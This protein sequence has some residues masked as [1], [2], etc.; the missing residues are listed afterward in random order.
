[1]CNFL[2]LYST[3]VHRL[4]ATVTYPGSPALYSL[5]LLPSPVLHMLRIEITSSWI[6]ASLEPWFRSTLPG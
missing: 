2:H 1:M 5:E 3:D 4:V 6:R